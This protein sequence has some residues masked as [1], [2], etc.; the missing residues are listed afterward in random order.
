[1]S[2]DEQVDL[3]IGDVLG[4]LISKP[5]TE[6]PYE[7]FNKLEGAVAAKEE[8]KLRDAERQLK[9]EKKLLRLKEHVRPDA[10][11]DLKK[12]RM[13]TKI[14]TRGV[15]VLFNAI[16]KQQELKRKREE[17]DYETTQEKKKARTKDLSKNEF[18]DILKNSAESV[19]SAGD[20]ED[21]DDDEEE[22]ENQWDVLDDEFVHDLAQQV[23]EQPE[24]ENEVE[25]EEA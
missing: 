14:A 20:K 2:E 15:V 18:L 12:E 7:R 25:E 21:E 9:H 10:A 4:K 5:V 24:V 11:T 13:L 3:G 19:K 8:K 1:M 6:K 17:E 22:F 23:E 16:A